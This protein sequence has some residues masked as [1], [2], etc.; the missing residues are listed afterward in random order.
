MQKCLNQ[1]AELPKVAWLF[2][3]GKNLAALSNLTSVG[4][5]HI[6]TNGALTNIGFSNMT[7]I[8]GYPYIYSNSKRST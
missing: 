7:S 5:L 3:W 1:K 8:G 2:Y 6:N 4:A